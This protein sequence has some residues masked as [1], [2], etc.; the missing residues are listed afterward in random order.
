[1][2]HVL[3]LTGLV[4]ITACAPPGSEV[5]RSYSEAGSL[6][7]N[8]T[9]GEAAMNNKLVTYFERYYAI[10][11][12]FIRTLGAPCHVSSLHPILNLY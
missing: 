4:A 12:R 8:G 3:A 6:A 11:P 7:D 9:F 1:M 2:K 10:R 5:F